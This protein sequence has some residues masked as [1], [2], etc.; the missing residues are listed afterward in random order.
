MKLENEVEELTDKI[1]EYAIIVAA[2]TSDS[3]LYSANLVELIRIYR[4][5]HRECTFYHN[6][7]FSTLMMGMYHDNP[8]IDFSSASVRN[9]V[10]RLMRLYLVS[11]PK[12]MNLVEDV[13]ALYQL[14]HEIDTFD[15]PENPSQYVKGFLDKVNHALTNI[16]SA[17]NRGEVYDRFLAWSRL[18]HRN[19]MTPQD[20][21]IMESVGTYTKG[22]QVLPWVDQS[23]G[24]MICSPM[25]PRSTEVLKLTGMQLNQT[26]ESLR[27]CAQSYRSTFLSSDDDMDECND[28]D[29]DDDENDEDNDENDEDNTGADE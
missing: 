2:T 9:R 5:L 24:R 6:Y 19:E 16:N 8:E 15:F 14:D 4:A 25:I 29:N 18:D 3:A 22:V 12:Q 7:T 27:R 10:E 20:K 13:N 23:L 11:K 28:L 26:I 21:D 17:V 1:E